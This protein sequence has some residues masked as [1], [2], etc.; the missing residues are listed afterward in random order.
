MPRNTS[1]PGYIPWDHE[2]RE[3][4]GIQLPKPEHE[5]T[6]RVASVLFHS[7]PRLHD[8]VT[9]KAQQSQRPEVPHPI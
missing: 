5:F 2:V 7:L 6:G 8:L 1:T 3:D 4:K 9:S